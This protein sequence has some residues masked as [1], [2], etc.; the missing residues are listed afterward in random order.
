MHYLPFFFVNSN[1]AVGLV[2]RAKFVLFHFN[3][4]HIG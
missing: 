3:W 2:N 4:F 1:E